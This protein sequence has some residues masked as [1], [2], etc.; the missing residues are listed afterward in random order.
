MYMIVLR[1]QYIAELEYVKDQL[2]WSY[3]KY[4]QQNQSYLAFSSWIFTPFIFQTFMCILEW[5]GWLVH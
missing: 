3:L 5:I 2:K 4:H 1:L